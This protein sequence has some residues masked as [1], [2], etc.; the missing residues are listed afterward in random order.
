MFANA[1]SNKHV[2]ITVNRTVEGSGTKSTSIG[3]DFFGVQ[4]SNRKCTWK[5][6]KCGLNVFS[7][8]LL[9]WTTLTFY[10][11]NR[12]IHFTMD[13]R[14]RHRESPVRDVKTKIKQERLSPARPPRARRHSSG[15]SRDSSSPAP[16]RRDSRSAWQRPPT[17]DWSLFIKLLLYSDVVFF[18]VYWILHVGVI[19]KSFHV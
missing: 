5:F 13:N 1:L 11:A 17:E 19:N 18:V 12:Q 15:S 6:R 10:G 14:R 9:V 16:R 7:C 2:P 3:M 4:T 8:A